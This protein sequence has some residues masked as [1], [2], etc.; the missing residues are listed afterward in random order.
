MLGLQVPAGSIINDNF[1]GATGRRTNIAPIAF[2][3]RECSWAATKAENPREASKQ[4]PGTKK[5][6][7]APNFEPPERWVSLGQ[8]LAS[9]GF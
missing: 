1:K 3:L 4:P 2:K 9:R 7:L 6:K 8:F 5:K